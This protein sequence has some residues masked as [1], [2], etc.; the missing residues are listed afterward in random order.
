[1]T[2]S[3]ATIAALGFFTSRRI[4]LADRS[5]GGKGAEGNRNEIQDRSYTYI[6][7]CASNQRQNVLVRFHLGKKQVDYHA[8]AF[9]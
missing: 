7:T 5:R 6:I 1:M 9:L 3:L 2:V 8:K 4:V